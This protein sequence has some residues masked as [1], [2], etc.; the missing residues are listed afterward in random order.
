M[1]FSIAVTL[2]F[3]FTLFQMGFAFV[4]NSMSLMADAIHNFGDVF[5]LILAW[6]ANW[7]LTKPARKRYSY[8]YKRTTILA[9]LTNA[10]I[11]VATSAVISYQSIYKLLHISTVNE[12]IVI[13]V[14]LVGIAINSGTAILFMR[15]AHDDLNIKGAFL[16][17][18]G[19]ALISFGVVLSAIVIYFTHWLWLDPLIGLCIVLIIIWGTWGLLRD[20]VR[21]ILDAVPHY[22]DQ[23]GIQTYLRGLS[24]VTA[25]H[26]LHIWGLSTKEIALTA[27]L[28]MPNER[29][30]DADFLEINNILKKKFRIDHATLQVEAG[31]QEFPCVRSMQC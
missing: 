6:G 3:A 28:I 15:G 13:I 1:A 27:H 11:L 5:G 18:L 24:G 19:D 8:G 21:L 10:L 12:M 14:A 9:A 4:A 16:H 29:L 23:Q 2:N 7:L 20:S 30:T 17:L 31:N 26:D 22:I 25:V